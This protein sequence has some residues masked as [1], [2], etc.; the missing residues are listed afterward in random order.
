MKAMS[1]QSSVV[2]NRSVMPAQPGDDLG[3]VV[4]AAAAA[5]LP[6]V[7][8]GGF[9]AQDVLALGVG[10]A[11][12]QPEADPEPGQAVLG[13]LDH[14]LLRGRA[15]RPVVMR[16]VLQAEQGPQGRDVQPGPGPVDN[17]VK[18][19]FH[20]SAGA[21]QQ[22]AAVL[23]LVDGVAVAEP[24]HALLG[25][26]QAEAQAR[27]IDPPVADLAQAPYSRRLRQG[28]CDPGQ[29][30]R[31]RDVSKAV[32]LLNKPDPCRPGLR[33]D[34]LVPVEDH[35]R[36]ERRVPGHLDRH[37]A[38]LGVHDVEAVVVDVGGL[39][40]DVADHAGGFRAADLPH[41]RRRLGSQHQE[42]PRTGRRVSG[43]MLLGDLVL[44]LPGPAVDHRDAIGLAPRLDAAGEPAR[45][46]HQ[47][48]IVQVVV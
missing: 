2:A 41:T 21:E 10:L 34:V 30:L 40:R 46:P 48:R 12:E 44:A 20:L 11:L 22:V 43:Q 7:V 38:P 3:E 42:H 9:E 1:A 23:G 32:A 33:C 27:R 25:Q 18:Q 39:L 31:I 8:H 17:P 13:V 37:M 6:G 45:H 35:L 15:G 16:P 29:A 14:D 28:I 24:A 19:V 36:G 26:V 47:V 5:Q 4:D